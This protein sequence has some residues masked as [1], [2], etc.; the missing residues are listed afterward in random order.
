MLTR[1]CRLI[2]ALLAR[3]CAS[4]WL[5]FHVPSKHLC[6]QWALF[7]FD[8]INRYCSREGPRAETADSNQKGIVMCCYKFKRQCFMGTTVRISEILCR[9]MRFG[10]ALGSK[11]SVQ[12]KHSSKILNP[13]HIKL[14]KRHN[15]LDAAPLSVPMQESNVSRAWSPTSQYQHRKVLQQSTERYF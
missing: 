6:L 13:V 5:I 1:L 9:Q 10:V 3:S 11:N 2:F 8:T 15:S 12:V 14:H 4:T 7:S